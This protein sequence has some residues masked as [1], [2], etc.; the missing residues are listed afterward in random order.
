MRSL[1]ALAVLPFVLCLPVAAS[2][3]QVPCAPRDRMIALFTEQFGETRRAL[4]LA[5]A[6]AV[7]ELFASDETGSW[8][9][10]LTLPDG[11]TCVLAR[12]SDYAGGA[13]AALPAGRGA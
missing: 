6:Q 11:R 4:G 13:P 12:G 10:A 2:A 7:M 5:G 1:A 8:S 3:Q 9:I